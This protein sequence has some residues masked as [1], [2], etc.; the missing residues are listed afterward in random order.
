MNPEA[1]QDT[2]SMLQPILLLVISVVL[3]LYYGCRKPKG[4]PPGPGWW[5]IL[6]SSWEVSRLR[7]TTGSLYRT[8][9]ALYEKYGPVV[10]LKIGKDRIVVLNSYE[11]VR[12]MMSNEDCDGRPTGPFY[13]TRT[14]GERRGVLLT[15]GPLWLEQ[16]RFVLRHLREFGFG[17]TD[18]AILIEDEASHLV[19]HIKALL[20]GAAAEREVEVGSRSK[21][22]PTNDG[23]I[24]RLAGQRDKEDLAP[25]EDSRGEVGEAT[26]SLKIEDVYVKA[27]D[28]AEVRRMAQSSGT[29]LSMD[30]IFG[31]PVLNSLWR[32]MAG[33]R[34]STDDKRMIYLQ[35][36]LTKLLKKVDMVGCLFSHFPILRYVAPEMSGYRRFV[37]TH[38]QLWAFFDAELQSHKT[39]IESETPRDL[40][41][42]YL[43]ILRSENYNETFSESQ[44]LAICMDLFMA[45]SETT[46]KALS[47]SFLYFVLYPNV[48][49]K[50]QEEIDLVV[51]RDR[52]PA[53]TDRPRLPYID[54]IVLE[55]VRMFMGRTF[56]IPHRA[57]RDTQIMGYRIP[58]DTMIIANF[59]TVLMGEFWGDPEVFRPER[60]LNE[61]GKVT[62]PDRYLP[63]GF[64]KHRC[65]GEMLAKSNMFVIISALLQAF[66]FS[67][68]P[69]EEKPPIDIV[70]GV[71]PY[72]KP[73]R[74]L[75]S[76]RS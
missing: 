40:M 6:G 20:L 15:D 75:I 11:S 65:M 70:D 46:S 60:F 71:T 27:E 9:T 69:G 50:A 72:P 18:M 59:N 41:D 68:V 73:Y 34:F 37:D 31:V 14:W 33:K 51:G 44:L 8:C 49:R 74:V 62:I 26:R 4:Y 13:E 39:T 57:V 17:R 5:P 48:Q 3:F 47:F 42:S 45:G 7:R 2:R 1:L 22:R 28:Y 23:R 21:S 12:A 32:M 43:N 10:G 16:R 54:A 35:K 53:L 52:F 56:S 63:F 58:K 64:G 24:Y 61:D 29:I 38:Q 66:T 30:D 19:E 55:S 36:I 25:E 76:L 67:V